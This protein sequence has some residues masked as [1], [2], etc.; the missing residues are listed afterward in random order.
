MSLLPFYPRALR[1][2][3]P[4]CEQP[5]E[6]RDPTNRNRCFASRPHYR[7]ARWIAPK[8]ES[9]PYLPGH[10]GGRAL[11]KPGRDCPAT[12]QV[13]VPCRVDYRGGCSWWTPT[14]FCRGW[15]VAQTL[16][17]TGPVVGGPIFRGVVFSRV[18][19]WV[20]VVGKVFCALSAW[21]AP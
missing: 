16:S 8:P 10:D 2:G 21:D 11:D 7:R 12:G 20:R 6:R 17:V 9:I 4:T 15:I 13:P 5:R 3:S 14:F 1:A 19:G 18:P